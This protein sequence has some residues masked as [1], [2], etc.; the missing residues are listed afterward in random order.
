MISRTIAIMARGSFAEFVPDPVSPLFAT[1]AVPI[2]QDATR[3]MINDFVGITDEESY[4]FDV[5]NGYVYVG[6]KNKY[7]GKMLLATVT[8]SKKVLQNSK[9][10]WEAR[11]NFV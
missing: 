10:R 5:V 3:K 6:I 8:K 1:L 2:A 7:M 9:E 11:N 4:L